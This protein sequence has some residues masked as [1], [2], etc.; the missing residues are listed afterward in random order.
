[1]SGL[2]RKHVQKDLARNEYVIELTRSKRNRKGGSE[3]VRLSAG[4]GAVNAV[5]FLDSWIERRGIKSEPEAVFIPS[6][7]AVG[8]FAQIV[9]P[10]RTGFERA[11][12][13]SPAG[14]A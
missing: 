13:G 8:W 9:R 12:T 5:A 14:Q 1:M 4:A 11:S 2:R 10:L 6:I 7:L 3:F